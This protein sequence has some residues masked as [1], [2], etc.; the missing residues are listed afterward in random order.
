MPRPGRDKGWGCERGV[1]FTSGKVG[2]A[3]NFNGV[4][5]TVTFPGSEYLNPQA[6]VSVEMWVKTT[7]PKRWAGLLL[8][9][10]YAP[11]NADAF[12]AGYKMNLSTNGY[13]VEMWLRNPTNE[14]YAGNPKIVVDGVWHHVVGTYDGTKAFAY[15]DGCRTPI[16]I[17]IG[18]S[19]Q[20]KADTCSD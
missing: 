8:K 17:H 19:F 1:T 5:G 20:F 16:P 6:G 18:Q 11:T 3:F 7:T 2:Q 15:S 14:F 13:G 10:D 4:N 9:E 12:K